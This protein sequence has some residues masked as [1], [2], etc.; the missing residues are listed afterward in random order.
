MFF[1]SLQ[2]ALVLQRTIFEKK[3]EL[4]QTANDVPDV[5][6]AI[7]ELLLSLFNTTVNAEV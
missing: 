2:D 3:M 5:R 1:A 6:L 4:T 7:Q